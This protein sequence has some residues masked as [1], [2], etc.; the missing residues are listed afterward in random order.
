M[1]TRRILLILAVLIIIYIVLK[2]LINYLTIGKLVVTTNNNV[3]QISVTAVDKISSAKPLTYSAIGSLLTKLKAGQYTVSVEGA[4]SGTSESFNVKAH[5]TKHLYVTLPKTTGVEPIVYDKAQDV[6]ADGSNLV[7]FNS[8]DGSL[9][10]VNA[11]NQNNETDESAYRLKTID[12]A[13]TSYGIGQSSSGQLYIF[14]NGT[15]SPLS[16]PGGTKYNSSTVFAI[17]S[18]RVIY[19]SVDSSVYTKFPTGEFEKIYTT[20]SPATALITGPKE[21]G[22]VDSGFSITNKSVTPS[23]EVVKSSGSTSSIKFK[24]LLDAWSNWSPDGKYSFIAGSASGEILDSSL[25]LVS[26]VPNASISNPVWNG[27]VLF[28][29]VSSALW[30]FNPLTKKATLV[31]NM[32]LGDLINGLSVSLDRTYIY[33]I[34][35]DNN[36]NTAIRRMSLTGRKV[37]PIIYQ[38]QD[39]LPVST[40]G[41]GYSIGLIDFSGEP[42]IQIV[43]ADG[44]PSNALQ[45]VQQQ[46][47]S[48]GFDLS[49]LQFS[50]VQG[51]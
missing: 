17:N 36:G 42:T 26:A 19:V 6:V 10:N 5:A 45:Q 4:S 32:P 37:L 33:I 34:S 47:Q 3:N 21:V 1:K 28:Y 27:D 16:A 40:P 9:N 44:G 50:V 23:L 2:M 29:N 38:L 13:S 43:L 48:D 15:V 30:S 7:Y 41:A 12:W 46:L 49:Q 25:H 8:Q 39:I 51:D 11:K 14:N 18:N 31:A 20:K 22:I 35:V 24:T